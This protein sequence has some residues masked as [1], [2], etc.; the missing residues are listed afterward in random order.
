MKCPKDDVELTHTS[1]SRNLGIKHKY[2]SLVYVC[3]ICHG[4]WIENPEV[5]TLKQEQAATLK[6][7][8]A[9]QATVHVAEKSLL[10]R[11]PSC[12]SMVGALVDAGAEFPGT[13]VCSHCAAI[14]KYETLHVGRLGR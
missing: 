6:Q 14:L 5:V 8:Q 1:P 12:H 10:V 11:C 7:E 4:V 9:K 2:V 13:R 3:D